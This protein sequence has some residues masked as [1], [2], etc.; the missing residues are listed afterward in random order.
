[1]CVVGMSNREKSQGKR[2]TSGDLARGYIFSLTTK[3][4]GVLCSSS[5]S[6]LTDRCLELEH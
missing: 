2:G 1:M 6:S 4:P 5:S 3:P